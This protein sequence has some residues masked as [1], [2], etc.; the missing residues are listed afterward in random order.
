[1]SFIIHLAMTI[2]VSVVTGRERSTDLSWVI[3]NKVRTAA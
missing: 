3:M 2:V 1:M